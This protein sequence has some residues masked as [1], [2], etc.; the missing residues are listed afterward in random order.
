MFFLFYSVFLNESTFNELRRSSVPAIFFCFISKCKH[1][2]HALPIFFNFS[3][4]YHS[5]TS[6]AIGFLNCDMNE[7]LCNDIGVKSYPT[8]GAKIGNMIG[9]I[10]PSRTIEGFQQIVR[11][12]ADINNMSLFSQN[13]SSESSVFEFI[14]NHLTT[15]K[16]LIYP[17]FLVELDQNSEKRFFFYGFC[18]GWKNTHFYIKQSQTPS[19]TFYANETQYLKNSDDFN[20]SFINFIND[21][22]TDP[23]DKFSLNEIKYRKIVFYFGQL[24]IT[25]LIIKYQFK[26]LFGKYD[27]LKEPRKLFGIEK[28]DQ[29]FVG[30]FNMSHYVISHNV[31][32]I[33]EAESFL[34]DFSEGKLEP[35]SINYESIFPKKSRQ[36]SPVKLILIII[37]VVT[38]IILSIV[39]LAYRA[40]K[41]K[42]NEAQKGTTQEIETP[43]D[44]INHIKQ[45]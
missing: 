4:L 2:R 45:D 44:T 25:P 26:Y 3:K 42:K 24:D 22:S 19:I 6:I 28:N 37:S 43:K 17:H 36:F 7:Q 8:F 10:R 33:E 14:N 38:L 31:S 41:K 29:A 9:M 21:F 32:S 35:K 11:Q 20:S 40:E 18:K 30:F 13:L 1:C 5:D 23:S 34:S 27:L 15:P 39:G 16:T 12:L